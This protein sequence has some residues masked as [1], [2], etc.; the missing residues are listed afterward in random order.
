MQSGD[1]TCTSSSSSEQGAATVDAAQGALSVS[2]ASFWPIRAR[3]GHPLLT[4]LVPRGKQLDA[5]NLN[6]C[7]FQLPDA[8]PVMLAAQQL[9]QLR[10]LELCDCR[11]EVNMDG[12][13][14]QLLASAPRLAVLKFC[15]ATD[16]YPESRL[17][18]FPTAI[19]SHPAL[20]RAEVL[21]TFAEDWASFRLPPLPDPRECG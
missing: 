14:L 20:V 15:S 21:S 19:F 10:Q 11:G 8:P 2:V 12:V 5:L 3:S 13:V 17:R 16:P 1:F 7:S 6:L 18:A 4:A 9:A